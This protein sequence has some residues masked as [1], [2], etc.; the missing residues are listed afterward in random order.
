ML[1]KRNHEAGRENSVGN[2]GAG[3]EEAG[4]E[5]DQKHIIYVYDILKQS[6]WNRKWGE[7]EGGS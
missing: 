2:G 5:F 4:V 7:R 6:I 1:N 3:R